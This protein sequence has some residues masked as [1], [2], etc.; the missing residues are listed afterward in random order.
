MSDYTKTN[1]MDAEDLA[2]TR[3]VSEMEARMVRQ[4]M[5]S[6]ELGVGYFRYGPNFRSPFGHHHDTQEE[7]YVVVAG[8]G[9]VKLDDDIHEL[10]LWDV[11]RVAPKVVRAFEGGPQGMTLIAIGGTRP[12]DGD[13][14]IVPGWWPAEA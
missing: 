8:G 2:A 5:D 1:L 7:A 4:H 11:V 3:G 12:P 14:N 10:A 6:E 13:G 9:L